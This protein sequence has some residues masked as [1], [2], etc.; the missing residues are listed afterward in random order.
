MQVTA[1][2]KGSTLVPHDINQ[3]V[4]DG[5]TAAT[6]IAVAGILGTSKIV[7]VVDLTNNAAIARNTVN[8]LAGNIRIAAVTTGKKLLVTWRDDA[9]IAGIARTAADGDGDL[10]EILLA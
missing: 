6:N 1:G 7:G 9:V 3:A 8:T 4:V 10:F 5:T 2:G